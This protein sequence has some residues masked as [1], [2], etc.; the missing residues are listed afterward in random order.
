MLIESQGS[1]E[2]GLSPEDCAQRL[3][4]RMR[5]L[6]LGSRAGSAGFSLSKGMRTIIRIRGTFAPTRSGP[7]HVDY[8]IEFIP[9]AMFVLVVST[10]I[11]TAVLAF[12][13]TLT[14]IAL[15]EL[16]PLIPLAVLVAA[17]NVWTSERQAQWLVAFVRRELVGDGD[18]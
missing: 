18:R 15:V 14:H 8:R 12:L 4:Q 7:T 13:L 9:D 10:V 2:T 17:A 16:W 1:F 11:G 6:M 3:K 5:G